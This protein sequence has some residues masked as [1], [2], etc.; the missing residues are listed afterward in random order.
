MRGLG[1]IQ[2]AKPAQAGCQGYSARYAPSGKPDD[3]KSCGDVNLRLV[4]LSMSF[5]ASPLATTTQVRRYQVSRSRVSCPLAM[6]RV[7]QLA[8]PLTTSQRRPEFGCTTDIRLASFRTSL[9]LCSQPRRTS[10]DAG[11][12]MGAI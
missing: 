3:G 8:K 7:F 12:I 1:V 2:S 11:F 9:L 5:F 4:R 6:P 10:T